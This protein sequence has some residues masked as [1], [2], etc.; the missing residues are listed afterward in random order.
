MGSLSLYSL[1]GGSHQLGLPRF[2]GGL[3]RSPTRS[4]GKS[5]EG[6]GGA[7]TAL[8]PILENTVY[9]GEKVTMVVWPR[10]PGEEVIT[11]Q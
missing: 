1:S 4:V 11:D 8:W 10:A 3:Y 7:E 2:A 6:C 9:L 5:L